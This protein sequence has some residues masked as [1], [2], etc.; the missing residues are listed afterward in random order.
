[1]RVPHVSLPVVI[2]AGGAGRRLGGAKPQAML[3]G[4]SLFD[5][6][7]QRMLPQA[8]IIAISGGREQFA[9]TPY[10]VLPDDSPEQLG[11]LAGLASALLWA[12]KRGESHVLSVPCDAPFLPP[13]LAG[14]LTGEIGNADVCVVTSDGRIHAAI[15]LWHVRMLPLVQAHLAQRH[16]A[17]KRLLEACSHVRAEWPNQ[18]L[19]PFF[20][21]NTPIELFLAGAMMRLRTKPDE[22]D[23]RG[24]KCP[25]PALRTAKWLR[26]SRGTCVVVLCTDPMAQI[27]IPH[28]VTTAGARL[29]RQH[30]HDDVLMFEIER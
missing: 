4:V 16:R 1:M 6:V 9:A 22:L 11:P 24:L 25:L 30:M 23:L 2:L 12:H 17:V 28:A 21:V 13:D 3:A 14:R 10:T 15:G 5:H 26:Q 27:D 29:V 20:N 7:L 8:K 18:P 19:D